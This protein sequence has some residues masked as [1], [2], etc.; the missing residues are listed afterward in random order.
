MSR[1][2]GQERREQPQIL[3]YACCHE[4]YSLESQALFVRCK[5]LTLDE[6]GVLPPNSRAVLSTDQYLQKSVFI[7][8][9]LV[10]RKPHPVGLPW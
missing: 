9:T 3:A 4:A 10:M 1:V 7:M 5:C 2:V 6:D 8:F